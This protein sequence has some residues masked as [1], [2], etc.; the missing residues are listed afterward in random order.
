MKC[1]TNN[2]GDQ[3]IKFTPN[4]HA[5]PFGNSCFVVPIAWDELNKYIRMA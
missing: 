3:A 4:N 2:D 5:I 1:N